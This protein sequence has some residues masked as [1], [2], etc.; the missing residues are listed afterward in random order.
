M[1]FVDV[2]QGSFEWHALRRTK[3]GASSSP[4]LLNLSPYK[5][6]VDVYNEMVFGE[7]GYVNAAM[8]NGTDKEGEARDYFNS[9]IPTPGE[10]YKFSPAVVV[11]EEYDFL[12]A[13]LD[14]INA[15]HNVILEI[16]VPGQKVYEQCF[17]DNVPI[18]WEYQIQHQLAVTGLDLAILFVYRSPTDNVIVR[19]PRDEKKIAEIVAACQ[20]FEEENL[21]TF[22]CP[23]S[24]RD[25][26]L[27]SKIL[28]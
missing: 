25:I 19:Y 28:K 4:S 8:Q 14:G 23:D 9:I 27:W 26:K 10:Q 22:T 21:S 12:M 24:K 5:T 17:L 15:S 1:K 18:H 7:K 11:S 20:K 13:S 3:I 6:P 2:E 16:K